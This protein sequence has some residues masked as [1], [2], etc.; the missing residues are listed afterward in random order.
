MCVYISIYL[1]IYIFYDSIQYFF[2][3]N[4][5][6]AGLSFSLF[7][8]CLFVFFIASLLF[9]LFIPTTKTKWRKPST[10]VDFWSA[11]FGRQMDGNTLKWIHHHQLFPYQHMS[12]C[13]RCSCTTV[14]LQINCRRLLLVKPYSIHRMWTNCL[15]IY[16]GVQFLNTI[17]ITA[18]AHGRRA[19][20]IC[21]FGVIKVKLIF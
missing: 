20:R 10:T 19:Y 13:S 8:F 11:W 18:S 15:I 17:S 5:R 14:W 7:T 9:N 4:E 6:V 2:M 1:F 21:N 3:S 12:I 16:C